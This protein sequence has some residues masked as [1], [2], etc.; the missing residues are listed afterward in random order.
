MQ[1]KGTIKVWS[2]WIESKLETTCKDIRL[3]RLKLFRRIF[4]HVTKWFKFFISFVPGQASLWHAFVSSK[5]PSQLLPPYCGCG[6]LQWRYLCCFPPPQDLSH[7]LQSD[8][9]EN[10]PSIDV[11]SKQRVSSYQLKVT[12]RLILQ[13]TL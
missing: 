9:R 7:T 10:P 5:S 1:K 3:L 13:T 4:K 12:I 11:C 8:Q 2:S 6:E